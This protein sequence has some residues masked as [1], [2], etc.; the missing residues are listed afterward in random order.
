MHVYVGT[1]TDRDSQGIHRC[2]FDPA[3]GAV[4]AAEPAAELSNPTFLEIDPVR[5]TLYTF[6][7]DRD[8]GRRTGGIGKRSFERYFSLLC[9]GSAGPSGRAGRM[10]SMVPGV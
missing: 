4:G 1:Y 3:T 6:S 7:E 8:E 10:K 5:G 9:R 2:L